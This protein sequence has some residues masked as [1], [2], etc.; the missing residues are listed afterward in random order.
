MK[1]TKFVL[2]LAFLVVMAAGAVVGMAV[3]RSLRVKVPPTEKPHSRPS[4]PPF[5]KVSPEQ[6]AEI[7]KIW[8][9]VENL[10]NQRF[11]SRR[12]LDLARAQKIQAILTPDQRIQYDAIQKE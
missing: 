11:T 7:D 8:E 3:D 1:M 5:P 6:K 9:A 12:Q 4:F 2:V 10:R